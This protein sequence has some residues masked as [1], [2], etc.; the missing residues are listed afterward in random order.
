MSLDKTYNV[1]SVSIG[2]DSLYVDTLAEMDE[3]Q[4]KTVYQPQWYG[5]LKFIPR[6]TE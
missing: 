5:E 3:E 1:G 2:P 4:P 6:L